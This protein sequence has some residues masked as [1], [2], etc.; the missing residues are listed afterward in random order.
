MFHAMHIVVVTI[1]GTIRI[2]FPCLSLQI[3]FRPQSWIFVLRSMAL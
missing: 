2:Y 1:L 3:F